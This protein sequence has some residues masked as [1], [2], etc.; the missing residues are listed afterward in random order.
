MNEDQNSDGFDDEDGTTPEGER[1]LDEFLATAFAL[2]ADLDAWDEEFDDLS[3]VPGK[4]P[5]GAGGPPTG[6]YIPMLPLRPMNLNLLTSLE[7]TIYWRE[8]DAWVDRILRGDYGLGT[9]HVPPLWHR[10]PELR[11]ELSALHTAWLASYDP[12]ASAVA[13]V[14]WQRE[15][16]DAKYR[17]ADWVAL[18]GT[19]LKE[20][21][22]TPHTHW[23]G[24]L[25]FGADQSWREA[26]E[27]TVVVD[28]RADFEEWLADD[29]AARR[30][31][32]AAVQVQIR[33]GGP[34]LGGRPL[35]NPRRA[36]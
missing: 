5:A 22:P 30:A 21:R 36:E 13:P 28:R 11:W 27:V 9:Q 1:L 14:A 19:G 24:E 34:V 26:A 25:G 23:P 2:P 18:A 4:A 15:L 10:H 8:L 20:N 29:V 12:E 32:E 35:P 7:A 31:V 33:S 17:L 6:T 3:T 16:A